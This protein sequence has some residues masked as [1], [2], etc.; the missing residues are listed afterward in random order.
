MRSLHLRHLLLISTIAM[1]IAP[2]FAPNGPATAIG[3]TVT[4][5]ALLAIAGRSAIEPLCLLF[6]PST[7]PARDEQRRRGSFR[8]QSSPDTP[9]KPQ[10]RAPG[11]HLSLA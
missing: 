11:T 1:L 4:V 2:A 9:G 7:G 6:A 10:P 8:R 3:A 5:L